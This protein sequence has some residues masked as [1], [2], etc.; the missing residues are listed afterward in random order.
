MT[1][2][3]DSSIVGQPYSRVMSI[4][5]QY[6][7]TMTAVVDVILQQ[8]VKLLDG[9][10]TPLGSSKTLTFG[11]QPDD[12]MSG[13]VA[14]RDVSTGAL[15]G[16]SMPMGQLFTGVASLIREKELA[17]EAAANPPVDPVEPDGGA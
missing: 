13:T 11:I 1:K 2:Q 16:A 8:H 4:V 9:T 5:I 6:T 12:F 7:A 17:A 10:H 15:L 14:L 3:F